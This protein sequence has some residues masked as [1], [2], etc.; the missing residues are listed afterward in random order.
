[1]KKVK[2]FLV[3]IVAI[4]LM[5]IFV[6]ASSGITLTTDKSDLELGDEVTVTA[7]FEGEAK[8]Y[9]LTATLNY[10]KDVF[11]SLDSNSL[12]SL[13]DAI[14]VVYN[15]ANNKFG[16]VNKAGDI[17][18]ELFVVH[19]KV[20]KNANVGDANIT[21]T[22]IT[23]SDGEVK[24]DYGKV[25][26]QVLV[27]KDAEDGEVIPVNQEKEFEDSEENIIEVFT[28]KPILIVLAGVFVILGVVALYFAI[29]KK[30]IKVT[31]GLGVAMAIVFVS[32]IPILIMNNSKKDVNDDGKRDYEDTKEILKY[33]I[34]ME[35]TKEDE[36]KQESTNKNP[37]PLK[38]YDVNNDG[39]VDINDAGGSA[40]DT[41]NKT[42]YKVSLSATTDDEFYIAKGKVTL[43]FV[44]SVDPNEKIKEVMVNGS[45]YPVVNNNT[46]YSVTVDTPNISGVCEFN[47]TKVKLINNREVETTLGIKKEVLKD[48]PYVDMFNFD[49]KND[50]LSF[51]LEDK[52]KAFISGHIVIADKDGNEVVTEEIQEENSIHY[53]FNIGENYSVMIFATYDLDTNTYNSV[54][55]DQNRVENKAIYSHNLS[56]DKNYDFTIKNITITDAIEKGEKPTITFESTNSKDYSVEYIVIKGVRYEAS[57]KYGTQQYVVTLDD[58]DTSNFGRYYV[59]IEEVEISN[60]KVFKKD[61]DYQANTLSYTVLKNAPRVEN[62]K[63]EDDKVNQEIKVKYDVIDT[64]KTLTDLNLYLVDPDN[65]IVNTIYSVQNGD[66]MPVSYK[67]N[68]AGGY[69]VKFLADYN[70]GTDRHSYNDVN[71]GDAGIITQTDVKI[72]GAIVGVNNNQANPFPVKNQSKYQIMYNIT[73]S[74]EMM[75][76]YNRF[77]GVTINGLNFDGSSN[78]VNASGDGNT[79]ISFTVPSESGVVNLKV[80]R[81][82]LSVES[83]QGVSQAYFAVVPYE[84]QIDVLKDK[85]TIENLEVIEEDYN[86]KTVTFKFKVVDDNGGFESGYVVLGNQKQDIVKG[87]NTITFT[88]IELGKDLDLKFYGNYD[89]DSNSIAGYDNTLNHYTDT[90]L[91]TTTYGLY[92]EDVYENI[93]LIDGVVSSNYIE[94][95]TDIQLSFGVSTT[96]MAFEIDKVIID[97]KEYKADIKDNNYVVNI[98]GYNAA[99]VKTI[100]INEVVLKNGKKITLAKPLEV[101]VEVLKDKVSLY[102]FKYEI[103]DDNIKLKLNLKDNDKAIFEDVKQAVL[104]KVYDEQNNLLYTLPYSDEL[105]FNRINGILRYYIK[106]EVT[107][108]RDISRGG[109]NYYQA[110]NILDDVISIDKNYIEIKDITDVTLYKQNTDKTEI[111]DKVNVIDIEANTGSYFV[112]I[113]MSKMP[114]V[115]A[116]I[117]EVLVEDNHLIL[118]LDYEYVVQE[119]KKEKQDLRIDYGEIATDGTVENTARPDSLQTLI[120]KIQNNPAAN[121]VL[122]RDYDISE[123]SVITGALFD[124]NFTGSFDGNGHTISNLKNPLFKSIT[125]GTVKNIKLE[126]VN[127]ASSVQ[128]GTIANTAS[129]ADI[130][131]IIIN[132]IT[133]SGTGHDSGAIVGTASNGTTIENCAVKNLQLNVGWNSQRNGGLVGTLNGST[134][135][136]CYVNGNVSANWNYIGGLVGNATNSVITNSY[137]KGN[138]SGALSCEINCSTSGSNGNVIKN[139][140]SLFVG[141]RNGFASRYATLEN[142]Y[143]LGDVTGAATNGLTNITKEQVNTQLFMDAQFSSD[144]WNISNVNYDNTPV[145]NEERKSVLNLQE[146]GSNYDENKELLY[147]NLMLL[148]PYYDSSKIVDSARAIS[149]DN[150]LA[151]QKIAHIIPID[152]E[153]HLVSYLTTDKPNKIKQIVLIFDNNEVQRYDVRY[154]KT[155]DMIASYRINSLLIDYSYNHYVI[156]SN[157]QLVNNLTNYLAS[158]SYLDNLDILTKNDDSR[159]YR[160]FYEEVTKNELKEFVLKYLANSNYA[161]TNSNEAISDYIEREVKED[162]KLVKALYVYNYLRKFYSVSFDGVMLNDLILF[163]SRGFNTDLTVD[164]ITQLFLND[165]KNFDTNRTNDVYKALLSKYTGLTNITDLMAFYVNTLTDLD[166]ATWYAQEFKGYLK[167]I[168]VDDNPNI[169]YRLWDHLTHTDLNTKVSWYNYVLPILTIPE[170]GAY[171]ISSPVQ[172]II[173]SQRTY[174]NDPNDPVEAAKLMKKIEDYSTRMKDYYTTAYRILQ[175]EKIFNDIHTVQIDKRYVYE[176]GIM[177]FQSP[178]ST[179]DAFHK[180]F[181]E[182]I[183]QWAYNDYNAATANG[184]YVIW[185]V[186][187]VMDGDFDAG[188]EYTFHTWSHESA[189]NIDARLFLRNYERRFDAGGEDYADGNLTQSF[190]DGD[191]VMNLS[192]HFTSDAKISANLDPSRIDSPKEIK[193]F[194]SKLFDTLYI[195]DYLE[196]QAFLKLSAE[197]QA[198]LAVQANYP[199]ESESLFDGQEYLKRQH[200]VYKEVTVEEIQQ[201]NLDDMES[202]YDGRLV[203]WPGVIY[204]TYTTNRYG[205]ENIYKTRWYQPHND[206]G[207]PDSYSLKWLAYEMMGYAGYDKGYVAY[208]SNINS[209]SKSFPS[210]KDGKLVYNNEGVQQFYSANYKTDLMALKEIT[211]NE[212]ITFKDYKLGRF[213]YVAQ[214][215]SDIQQ[216]NVNEYFN[217]FYNA[218][219]TD[220]T[221]VIKARKEAIEKYPEGTD[222]YVNNRNQYVINT[223]AKNFDNSVGVRRELYYAMKNG[224]N[225]FTGLVYDSTNQHIVNPFVVSGN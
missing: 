57:L 140:V 205:G 150:L 190:G 207:R 41:T 89:L 74:N 42:N 215:L 185:R 75:K 83:Y 47:I 197:E 71:V 2:Y 44:A 33:L 115:Y 81:V 64:D 99:G 198:A 134:I 58:V 96:D 26:T 200:T 92:S 210:I 211:G 104:V 191:I 153:G 168:K 46:Y 98:P 108:D 87:E 25:S 11:E 126:K 139:N 30:N 23:S 56:I 117:K 80:N 77:T 5:P 187:G 84:T 146:V 167:E 32:T 103:S 219:K 28:N 10:D 135:N 27:T 3:V 7:K 123:I 217:K 109:E 93:E 208:Y 113:T 184:A 36:S 73:L 152:D 192:R 129:D 159:L 213:D 141:A 69:S 176:N 121:I 112:M 16:L 204:S 160:E 203:M 114:S 122:T 111:I 48:A 157:T 151:T 65:K 43:N 105:T 52:D 175:D 181:I 119:N 196:G 14:E 67:D 60:Y 161:I 218:L 94:K 199:R 85:P 194:Y 88:G 61:V 155:Y 51:K 12:V 130:N 143:R 186:E 183:G 142:N 97:N 136:N 15:P 128:Q 76:K 145:F 133:M 225:D 107:Y 193:D 214:H 106:I 154:D 18:N 78:A 173:G 91:Y 116:K 9:A 131:N 201:M 49:D 102:D 29:K 127:L 178:Y 17:G 110:E 13:N 86:T 63:L 31:L 53:E 120:E 163:N 124:V 55:G 70:L 179:Q 39:K 188:Y 19:L 95:L 216:I 79:V 72:T 4:L 189:H 62:I 82:K 8:I 118:I 212:N 158:L 34:E 20:K 21:L 149:N 68:L 147:S 6:S 90:E 195:M 165:A 171:I 170:N 224:T 144:I 24:T 156:D 38:D 162:Q 45:Y 180:Y 138:V 174:I 125:G 202:L 59:D 35:G 37:K 220:A 40:Q 101:K 132:N 148:M 164:K 22:N 221:A 50:I 66:S 177:T 223:K 209:V 1:M 54:T 182:A 169:Q 172:F 100:S 137:G 166:P 222:N 206:L